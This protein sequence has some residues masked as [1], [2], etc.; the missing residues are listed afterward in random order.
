MLHLALTQRFF[1]GCLLIFIILTGFATL[2]AADPVKEAAA[3]EEAVHHSKSLLDIY[4]EGGGIMHAI[5]LCSI[6]TVAVIGYCAT[7]ITRKN[8]FPVAVVSDLRGALG[9]QDLSRAY[10]V[11]KNTPCS[12]S[13]VMSET[14][15]KAGQGVSVYSKNDLEAAASETIFHE[16]TKHMLWVNM[17]NAFAAVAPMIGL[18]ATVSGMIESFDMLKQGKAKAS[19]FAGGIGEAMVGTAGGLI[20]AIP[21]MFCYFY[22]KN[23]LQSKV[24]ELTRTTSN[25]IGVFIAGTPVV[26]EQTSETEAV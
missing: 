1:L 16:E 4:E 24:S 21:A 22:F 15:L 25:L 2:R 23:Q 6:A 18:L 13:H 5:A 12:L 26:H 14:L 20:V 7:R 19:D 17:L 11:C 8:M 9:Q 3:K 10:D